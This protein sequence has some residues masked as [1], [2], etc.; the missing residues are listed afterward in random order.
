[1]K[2]PVHTVTR[3]LFFSALGLSGIALFLSLSLAAP[4]FEPDEQPIGYVGQIALTNVDVA[5]GSE[6][7][8]SIDYHAQNWRGNLH[9]YKVS[10]AGAIA[11]KDE[12]PG[13]A[14]ASIDAQDYDT[15]R[16]IV[17]M[18]GAQ[19]IPFRWSQL[20]AS[21]QAAL[22]PITAANPKA[23]FSPVLNFVR[24][25]RSNESL[26][27]S[28]LRRR[29]SVFGD[30]I[31]STPVYCPAPL[32]A[33]DTV[34][35][36]ANDGML[37]AIDANTG[38]E[39]FAYI[40]SV[41]IHKL[42]SLTMRDYKHR[43]F[44][45]GRMALRK[46]GDRTILVGA[47][48][49]GGKG[50]FALDVTNAAPSSETAA[51]AILL[52]EIT[53]ESSGFEKLGYIY[54]QPTLT[55]LKNGDVVLIVGNGYNNASGHAVLYIINPLTGEKIRETDSSRFGGTGS[56]QNPNGLSSP[57]LW[58]SQFDG[59]IDTAYA[60]DLEGTLWK[61]D[62]INNAASKLHATH[63][64]QA[65]TAMPAMMRHPL[66]GT[67]VIFATGR[68]LSQDDS[69]QQDHHTA[70]GIWDGAPASNNDLL[71]QSLTEA[72]YKGTSPAIRVRWATNHLPNWSNGHHKG[73]QTRF[74]IGGERL[75]GDGAFVTNGIFQFTTTNPTAN[76][77]KR[78]GDTQPYGE[79]WWMQLD[80][81][82]GGNIG[83][84][85]FDLNRDNSFTPADHITI[86]RTIYAPVGKHLGGGARSQMTPMVA[87][88][89]QIYHGSYDMNF[90]LS[91]ITSAIG[92]VSETGG[93]TAARQPN[94]VIPGGAVNGGTPNREGEI[95]QAERLGRINWREIQQ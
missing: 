89:F 15:E 38:K 48:G 94:G 42:N 4:T 28:G 8:F 23:S 90:F 60:G 66:G 56:A 80:A 1:M 51:A 39:R 36:G 44:V 92:I 70:Y 18:N 77:G 75:V 72:E 83:A 10:S 5:S 35:V 58:S 37:R 6:F 41:V 54:G 95:M 78:R 71:E 63:P 21:Q 16:F 46:I 47:L 34:F 14:A 32:C 26:A 85:V 40:P 67:M 43:Y 50:L 52:W 29:V 88:S 45:D 62:L 53:H 3:Q 87:G 69:M 55:R 64:A 27:A 57:S 13:G 7:V 24:G 82:T 25:D 33:A 86:G 49:A 11:S 9:K 68:M 12:W 20:S 76:T 65:I 59:H 22:D 84:I 73:W 17:T 19:K 81:L 61:F 93:G 74:P 30:I 31:H 79:N 2:I 91:P